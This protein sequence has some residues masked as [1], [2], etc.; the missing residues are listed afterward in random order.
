MSKKTQ[1]VVADEATAP[2]AD[3]KTQYAL[4]GKASLTV[5]EQRLK[6]GDKI[7]AATFTKLPETFAG[8]FEKAE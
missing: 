1:E 5:G 7:S 2:S 8:Y 4:T 3:K 6:K